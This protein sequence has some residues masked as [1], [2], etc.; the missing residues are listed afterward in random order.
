M[1]QQSHP[2]LPHDDSA[3]FDAPVTRF[4][5]VDRHGLITGTGL[6]KY[7]ILERVRT[8]HNAI[9]YK[10]R[11]SMLDRL[12]T[13][14]Q[15]N[16]G[17]IDDPI[18][19]GDFKREAQLLARLS[20]RSRNVT[21]VYELIGDETGFFIAEEFIDG[22]WLETQISKRIFTVADAPQI[23]RH[24]CLALGALQIERIVHR[25]AWPGNWL[26]GSNGRL[27]LSNFSTAT[28]EGD[29]VLPAI[30]HAKYTAPEILLA[31]PCDCRADIYSFGMML[32]EICVGRASLKAW[33]ESELGSPKPLE[34]AW[35]AWHV[36]LG[37][38]LPPACELN[39]DVP[40]ALAQLIEEML[41]KDVDER[42]GS[43]QQ[44]LRTVNREL[45]PRRETAGAIGAEVPKVLEIR[46]VGG[47]PGASGDPSRQASLAWLVREDQSTT[48]TQITSQSPARAPQNRRIASRRQVPVVQRDD[49]PK[50]V[51]SQRVAQ[52][53]PDSIARKRL[54]QAPIVPPAPA[55]VEAPKRVRPAFM[56]AAAVAIAV[57]V[58]ASLLV[59]QS[60]R[61][62][63]DRGEDYRRVAAMI[64]A[65]NTAMDNE[66]LD[67]ARAE[68]NKAIL[69]S[70]GS[71]NLQELLLAAR[72]NLLL[73][74]ARRQIESD[75]FADA[76]SSLVAAETAGA[77]PHRISALR[78]LLANRRAALQ[79]SEVSESK[80]AKNQFDQVAASLPEYRRYAER[81]GLDPDALDRKLN[82]TREDSQYAAAVKATHEA[83]ENKDFDTA[84]V[85]ARDARQMRDIP[86]SRRLIDQIIEAKRQHDHQLRGDRALRE[87]DFASA[88]AEYR[89]ALSIRPDDEIEKNLR[90]ATAARLF[91]EANQ[92]LADGD[93]L[94]CQRLLRNSLWQIR[95]TEAQAM[96]ER[97]APAFEAATMVRNA[98][99]AAENGDT[100]KAIQLLEKAIP[101][102]PSPAREQAEAKLKR[103]RR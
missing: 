76:E 30:V 102:L 47:T 89:E 18:A 72:T 54:P 26:V 96:L 13:L 23:L 79:I 50:T 42:V 99:R 82:K 91:N 61:A 1:T 22:D 31:E 41:Q 59:V 66:Q 45:A 103:L 35:R 95:S 12:V 44:I 52:A 28:R 84:L 75:A 78:D 15:L 48:T 21:H 92:A 11:D 81:A 67:A 32:Y 62:I 63:T 27:I 19:C 25:D 24:G 100:E 39:S 85:K 36:D 90:T 16:P 9:I 7:R 46:R 68:F 20:G 34:D 94:G 88:E 87:G 8:T 6:G 29:A 80:L 101:D 43:Y 37:K 49:R 4:Q 40:A 74:D 65:G 97:L 14:K 58:T 10:A 17:L 56:L 38:T 69:N 64:E 83:I 77:T 86:E 70:E 33:C 5:P 3:E 2:E 93:L 57:L 55:E 53:P 60:Y 71:E 51:I 98:D 73:L